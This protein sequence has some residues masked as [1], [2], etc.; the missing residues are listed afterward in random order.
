MINI[1]GSKGNI[2]DIDDFLK[3]VENFADKN[4]LK[5][6][7][8]NADL[9][10]A[11]DHI[12]SS[13]EHAKRAIERKTDTTNSLEKEILL[14]ASGERQLKLAIPK[15]G[16]KKGNVNIAFVLVNDTKRKLPEQ[17]TI[18]FLKFLKLTRDDDVIEGNIDT[19]RKFGINEEEIETV[20]KDKYG[21]L[22]LEKVAMVDIMK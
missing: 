15:M 7:A 5:I 14:Y 1:V 16:V 13:V 21:F 11:E 19:L 9:I 20:T 22:I 10:Y 8:F 3:K 12:K 2:E 18:D 6:Q 17:I 4:N